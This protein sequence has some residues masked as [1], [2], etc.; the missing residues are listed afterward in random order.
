MT[1]P[2]KHYPYISHI[3]FCDS[4]DKK[5]GYQVIEEAF[6]E[7]PADALR[8]ACGDD[9]IVIGTNG[10][11]DTS[12]KISFLHTGSQASFSISGFPG[13]CS[14]LILLNVQ[15]E[16]E[17]LISSGRSDFVLDV[18]HYAKVF[19]ESLGY[20]FLFLTTTSK[21]IKELLDTDFKEVISGDNKHSGKHNYFLCCTLEGE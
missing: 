14:A 1:T 21:S 8:N 7:E 17:F 2:R 12:T 18:V 20:R 5:P 4:P 15:T 11:A 19:A 16:F 13:N 9:V 6:G 3:E 10:Q